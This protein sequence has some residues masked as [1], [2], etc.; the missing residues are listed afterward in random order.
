MVRRLLRLTLVV[1]LGLVVGVAGYVALQVAQNPGPRDAPGWELMAELPNGR[2]ETAGAVAGGRLWV[3]G[4][5]AGVSAQASAEVSVYDPA[6]DAW[7]TGPSLPAARHHAAAVGLDGVVYVGGGGPSVADWTPQASFWALD[8]DADGGADADAGAWRELA[9]MPEARLGHR[10]V[11]VDGLVYV[12]GGIGETGSVLVYDPA[13]DA[14][15]TG[16]EMSVSRDHLAVV[17]VDGEIWAI[18]GRG[19]GRNHARVNIYDPTADAWREGPPLPEATSGAS[20]GVVG[21]VIF[22]SGGEDPGGRVIDGHW[23][24]D[25]SAASPSWEPLPAPPLVVH[26]APGFG[27]G[28]RF[29]VI[30]GSLRPGGQSSLAWTGATQ[31]YEP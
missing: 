20:E 30:G 29:Y 17:V 16:T 19:G 5:L 25:V 8:A 24:L 10:M 27:V 3:I 28:G 2:G 26:G 21:S 4:G 18:G 22:L 11:A 15:T 12:V 6:S 31:V 14:W 1:L 7:S 13:A 23:R 9:P